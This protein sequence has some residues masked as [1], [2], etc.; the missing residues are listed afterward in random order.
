MDVDF[1]LPTAPEEAREKEEKVHDSEQVK[2]KSL[3]STTVDP[4]VGKSSH[5]EGSIKNP[6]DLTHLCLKD[7][8]RE[9]IDL[10]NLVVRSYKSFPEYCLISFL[11]GVSYLAP[12]TYQ[13]QTT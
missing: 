6:I 11:E 5:K 8:I 3:K 13:R 12:Y 1:P 2:S 10:T 4:Q 7:H 9:V